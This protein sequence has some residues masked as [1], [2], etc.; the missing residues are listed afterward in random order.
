MSRRSLCSWQNGANKMIG[1]LALQGGFIEHIHALDRLGAAA[2]EIRKKA[3]LD[4]KSID[5]LILPGGESTVI[6]KL[7]RDLDLFGPLQKLIHHGT[8]AFGTCAGLILLAKAIAN[9]P[10]EYLSAMDITAQ[11]N[12]FGRQLGS[13]HTSGHFAGLGKI[14]MTFIRAPFIAAA[15]DSV[16][17]LSE[18][19]GHAVAAKQGHLLVT[20]FHP[21]LTEDLSVHRFFLENC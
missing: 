17:I 16:E 6:G 13:F 21:E 19:N 7:L 9:D 15:N 2:F 5:G 14:P 1:V 20:A 11:R 4:N 10:N 3:D 8:P 12:A 18:I